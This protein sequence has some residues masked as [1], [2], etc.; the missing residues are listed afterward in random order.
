VFLLFGLDVGLG[1]QSF[2]EIFVLLRFAAQLL[3]EAA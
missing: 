3:G 1:D 2:L